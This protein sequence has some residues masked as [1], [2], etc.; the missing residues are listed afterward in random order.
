MIKA[1]G[2]QQAPDFVLPVFP[3]ASVLSLVL[4]NKVARSG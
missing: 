4:V 2:K 1:V 3:I